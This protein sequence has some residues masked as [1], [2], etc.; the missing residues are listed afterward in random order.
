M[1]GRSATG[2]CR[3]FGRGS[4]TCRSARC[5]SKARCWTTCAAR[6][7]CTC[8]GERRFDP[9]RA[10]ALLARLGRDEAFLSQQGANLSGGEGQIVALV[11]VLLVEPTVLLLDEATASLDPDATRRVEALIV[12]WRREAPERACLWVSHDSAQLG[13]V[14]TRSVSLQDEWG[15]TA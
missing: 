8:I 4:P 1:A 11:R 10:L 3:P 14:A 2:G 5:S 9:E 12:D 13:R 15:V 7:R 6:S